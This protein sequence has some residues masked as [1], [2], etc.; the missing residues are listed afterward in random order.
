VMEFKS[1][2]VHVNPKKFLLPELHIKVCTGISQKS[3]L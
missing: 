3:A 1:M 2:L